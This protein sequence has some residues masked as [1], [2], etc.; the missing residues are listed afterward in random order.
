VGVEVTALHA[1]RPEWARPAAF[2]FRRAGAGWTLTG[3]EREGG[4]P[5]RT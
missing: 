4:I 5:P 2:F 3:V 1:Q